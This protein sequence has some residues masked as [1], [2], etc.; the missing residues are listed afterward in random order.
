MDESHRGSETALDTP[1]VAATRQLKPPPARFMDLCSGLGIDS[2]IFVD[3][4]ALL[5]ELLLEPRCKWFESPAGGCPLQVSA[6]LETFLADLI[7]C[8]GIVLER[9]H[10]L[11]FGD[12]AQAWLDPAIQLLRLVVITSLK[13]QG[14]I[15]HRCRNWASGSFSGL[16]QKFNVAFLL[17]SDLGG[18]PVSIA[19]HHRGVKTVGSILAAEARYGAASGQWSSAFLSQLGVADERAF[20]FRTLGTRPNK[21]LKAAAMEVLDF[22]CNDIAEEETD[23]L[24]CSPP[25]FRETSGSNDSFPLPCLLAA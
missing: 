11:S 21:E 6:A 16:L 8:Q 3:V 17:T 23:P 2:I 5:L 13:A 4:D 10:F 22:L 15:V 18:S 19:A 20:G 24:P 1:E 7:S 25:F 9:L 12:Q 14:A